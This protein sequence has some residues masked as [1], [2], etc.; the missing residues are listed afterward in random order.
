MLTSSFQP[1]S[2][3]KNAFLS[4]KAASQ[5]YTHLAQRVDGSYVELNI[6]SAEESES[7]IIDPMPGWD[8]FVDEP[9][10][11]ELR[12]FSIVKTPTAHDAHGKCI[13]CGKTITYKRSS[14]PAVVKRCV[15]CQSIH[16]L[17]YET[18]HFAFI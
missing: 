14:K 11:K 9:S 15:R 3:F 7:A 12:S 8:S 17:T 6:D 13:D 16:E 10:F 4:R 18:G 5:L 2:T 1:Q